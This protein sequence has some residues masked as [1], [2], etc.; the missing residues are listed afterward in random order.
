MNETADII[1]K[2]LIEMRKVTVFILAALVLFVVGSMASAATYKDTLKIALAYDISSLDPQIGK[3][4]RACVISQQIFDTLVEW[5]EKGGI[6]SKIVPALATNWEYVSDTSVQ[7][8][9]RRGV[10]FH[11]GE[12]MTADDVVYSIQRTMKSSHVGYYATAF[13][14]VEKVDDFTVIINTKGPYAPLLAGLTTTPFSIV[15]KSV[16]SSDE[17]G[18]AQHPVGTGRYKFVRYTRGDSAKLEAFDEC[19]R[20]KAPTKYIEMVIV[21]EN[22]QR[23]ILLETGAVDIAY[24]ILPNDVSKVLE[25]NQLKIATIDGAKCYLINYNTQSKGPLSKKLVRRAIE[26][27]IDKELLVDTVLYGY[28]TPAYIDVSPRNI[29]YQEVAPRKQDFEEAKRLLEEAGYPNGGF[30]LNLWLNTDA[31]WLQCAQ[32]IQ[33]E[34]DKV[35]IEVNIE[36]MES[37]ALNSR[38]NK[39]KNNFDMSVRFINSLTGDARFTLY[40]LLYSTSTSNKSFWKNPRADELIER[41]RSIINPA[42]SVEIYRELFDLIYEERPTLPVYF[43]KLVVGLNKNVEGFIPR[44]DGIHVFGNV[45]SIQ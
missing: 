34:L 32:I 36:V 17:N 38:E 20:G 3:E 23:T 11:N 42:Q 1:E 44:A 14:T 25:N 31:V 16:A 18:F 9:L 35:G 4:M 30:K 26:L 27:C 22:S 7:F 15:C 24:E 41:G 45:V 10:K 6:G 29:A 19:W 37:S 40:N 13:D 28:G 8:T 12:T 21:P 2:G 33:S 5:D 39:D 43:D